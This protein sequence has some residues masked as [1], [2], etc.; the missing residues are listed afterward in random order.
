MNVSERR[1][2]PIATS[3]RRPLAAVERRAANDSNAAIPDIEI[4]TACV[5]DRRVPDG[6]PRFPVAG[7]QPLMGCRPLAI[8][9]AA[10]YEPLL[11]TS[12]IF[13]GV[14]QNWEE[15]TSATAYRRFPA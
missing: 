10:G 4:H 3:R 13:G 8:E 7:K 1:D 15:M 2:S 6:R 14:A 9:T 12:A 11:Q 5:A